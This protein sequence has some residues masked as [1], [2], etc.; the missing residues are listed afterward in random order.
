V[1]DD[2]KDGATSAVCFQS[3]EAEFADGFVA[4]G[5]AGDIDF[6]GDATADPAGSFVLDRGRWV[7]AIADRDDFSDE[8]VT[9]NARKSW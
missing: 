1:I 9:G 2:A 5:C 8:F 4:V 3:A 7:A 6:A